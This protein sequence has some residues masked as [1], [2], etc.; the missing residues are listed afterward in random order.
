MLDGGVGY[1]LDERDTIGK[2]NENTSSGGGG[3]GGL[4]VGGM[5]FK[6]KVNVIDQQNV[7]EMLERLRATAAVAELRLD[8]AVRSSG[9]GDPCLRIGLVFFVTTVVTLWAYL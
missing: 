1:G 4:E 9:S 2:E 8:E 3:A 6:D 5:K 7:I